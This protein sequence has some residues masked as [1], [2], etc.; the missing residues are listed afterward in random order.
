L[1]SRRPRI[2]PSLIASLIVLGCWAGAVFV[3]QPFGHRGWASAPIA[4]LLA[5]LVVTIRRTPHTPSDDPDRPRG[6]SLRVGRTVLTAALVCWLGLIGWSSLSPGG[7]MPQPKSDA[8]IV[9]VVTWNILHGGERGTP[10][11]RYGWPVRKAALRAAL[12]AAKPDILCVQEALSEQVE[13][14]A[15][16]L[17]GHRRVG[18]G[19]DDG[20]SSGEH[21][22]IYFDPTRFKELGGGT[23]WLEEPAESPPTSILLGPKRICTWV[24]LR[25]SRSGHRLRVYNVHSYLTESA[26]VRAVRLTLD[27]IASGDPTDA[28][29]VAGDFNAVPGAPDRRLFD[30]SGIN[31]SGE[32]A[33]ETIGTPTYQFYG[34][35]TRSLDEI[36]INDGW[37]VVQHRILDVKPRNTFPSDHFGVMA[38]L[39]LRDDAS[40]S[41]SI[42]EDRPQ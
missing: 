23:F 39:I 3:F 5:S 21:C 20:R 41:G 14:V 19:R 10:W 28:V 35:R 36:L 7:V 27:R 25:D 2:I 40:A 26:R 9:R 38:D 33:G 15:D 42:R 17:P 32:L 24:R 37:R 6:R 31:S 12:E 22:A 18:V 8:A 13:S 16:M 4:A 1:A 34:I 11:S 30:Q 29:L